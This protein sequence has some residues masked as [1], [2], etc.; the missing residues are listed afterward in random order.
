VGFSF[1]VIAVVGF[2]TLSATTAMF[3]RTVS[4]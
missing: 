1:L 3:Q 4:A 2:I